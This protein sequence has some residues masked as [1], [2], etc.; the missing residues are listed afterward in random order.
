MS[1]SEFTI[2][3]LLRLQRVT[4]DDLDM[5]KMFFKQID[6]SEGGNIDKTMLAK[7]KL[8]QGYGSISESSYVHLNIES[9][10]LSPVRSLVLQTPPN[11]PLLQ[12]QLGDFKELESSSECGRDLEGQFSPCC[13]LSSTIFKTDLCQSLSNSPFPSPMGLRKM[14]FDQYHD[15]VVRPIIDFQDHQ[16]NASRGNS[17]ISF[18]SP[19]RDFL[20][21]LTNGSPSC[22]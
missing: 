12:F 3:E 6:T 18:T 7:A 17:E 9:S 11:S 4:I 22:E 16:I 21:S 14:T 20:F 10:L 8:F 13:G 5:I 19:I 15:S 1:L 2:L